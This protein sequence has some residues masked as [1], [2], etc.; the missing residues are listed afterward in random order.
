M[1]SDINRCSNQ[2]IVNEL[3]IKDLQ[4]RIT[5]CIEQRRS[6]KKD[7]ITDE[8]QKKRKNGISKPLKQIY[9][10]EIDQKFES[11][12]AEVKKSI[13]TK[14]RMEGEFNLYHLKSK[15]KLHS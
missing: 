3:K 1:V 4:K 8:Q 15:T 5:R 14:I 13:G 10:N 9:E 11:I 12:W 7:L 2:G 6:I